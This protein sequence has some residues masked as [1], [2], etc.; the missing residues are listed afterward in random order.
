MELGNL[1]VVIL[2]AAV[3]APLLYIGVMAEMVA[4]EPLELFGVQGVHSHQ[5]TLGMCK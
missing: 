4:A 3:A 1:M 5:Q 2:E